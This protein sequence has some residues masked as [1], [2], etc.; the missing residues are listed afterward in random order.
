MS[1]AYSRQTGDT[2][3]VDPGE[4]E[5]LIRR[6]STLRDQGDYAA[7]D[8]ILQSLNNDLKVDLDDRTKTWKVRNVAGVLAATD[9][10]PPHALALGRKEKRAA[11][12]GAPVKK[13]TRIPWP[14]SRPD[15]PPA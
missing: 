7:A 3:E 9:T 12:E 10:A 5:A 1:F 4:V 14:P 8:A 6:R 15:Q 2:A 11:K 13:L